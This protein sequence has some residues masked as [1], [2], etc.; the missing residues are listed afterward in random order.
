MFSE[1]ATGA[2]GAGELLSRTAAQR[3]ANEPAR[4]A[5]AHLSAAVVLDWRG[6]TSRRESTEEAPRVLVLAPCNERRRESIP[7]TTTPLKT[8]GQREIDW[9][10]RLFS[11]HPRIDPLMGLQAYQAGLGA[12]C[13][14]MLHLLNSDRPRVVELN[15]RFVT[16]FQCSVLFGTGLVR[17]DR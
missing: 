1:F 4:R 15:K 5:P 12:E 14:S 16:I 7:T 8:R 9:L 17:Q 6:F 13:A 11:Y 2:A 10:T 3:V